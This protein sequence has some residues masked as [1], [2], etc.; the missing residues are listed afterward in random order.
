MGAAAYGDPAHYADKLRELIRF[1]DGEL[2]LDQYRLEFAN[3]RF[4]GYYTDKLVQFLGLPPRA[5]DAPLED[6]HFDLAAACQLVFEEILFELLRWLHRQTGM[7]NL[8]LNGGCSMNSLAN[9]KIVANTEFRDLYISP[10]AADNGCCIAG[11]LWLM[12]RLAREGDA[13]R[14]DVPAYT[15]PSFGD[16]EIRQVLERYKIPYATPADLLG[17]TVELLCS[18]KIVGW[19][20]GAMEFGERALGNRSIL[21][22]PRDAAMKDRINQSVKY[23]EAFR[24]FAPSILAERAQEYFEMPAGMAVKFME[25]VYPVKRDKRGV[26]PAVVHADGTGRLQTVSAGDNPVYHAL[27]ERFRV[28][29]GIPLVLNTS[30]NLNGEPIVASPDDALRT[31]ITSGIDALVLGP[32]LLRKHH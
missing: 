27:I 25:Q 29:T 21:A 28:R 31:F 22:D 10:A 8:V 2:V 19:F 11:P 24:P 15:G 20:Q 14:V 18:G 6:A 32:F 12:H 1:H 16:A 23:R 7:S 26:V 13:F 4:G 9:G 3:M 30:F 17:E 5:E